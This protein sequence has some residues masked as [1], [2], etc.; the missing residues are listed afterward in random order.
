MSREHCAGALF[1]A[2][3]FVTPVSAMSNNVMSRIDAALAVGDAVVCDVSRAANMALVV[4]R[5]VNQGK[6]TPVVREGVTA[7]VQAASNAVCQ[8]LGG[9]VKQNA[10]ASR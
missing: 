9:V 3:W 8:N 6:T 2:L 7:T 4:E 5:A 1:S 10:S